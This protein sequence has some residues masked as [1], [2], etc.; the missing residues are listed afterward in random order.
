MGAP[1]SNHLR[2]PAPVHKRATTASAAAYRV[3]KREMAAGASPRRP[4]Q[5]YDG[6]LCTAVSD[7]FQC[8]TRHRPQRRWRMS[9]SPSSLTQ[10]G[11][12][13]GWRVIPAAGLGNSEMAGP[14]SSRLAMTSRGARAAR[15]Q[16]YDLAKGRDGDA[17]KARALQTRIELPDQ[18]MPA[19]E[20]QRQQAYE[21]ADA[22]INEIDKLGERRFKLTTALWRVK[23]RLS[24]AA[25][26]RQDR[27]EVAA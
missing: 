1:D 2:S 22:L 8:R 20:H 3:N 23:K 16:R 13:D 5:I 7:C 15:A 12:K 19:A 4:R 25:F 18:G 26:N 27:G 6:S 9:V 11:K 10:H 17:R 21:L 24:R 14:H